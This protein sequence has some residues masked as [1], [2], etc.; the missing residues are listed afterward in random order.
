[1][2]VSRF[3]PLMAASPSRACKPGMGMP[4]RSIADLTRQAFSLVKCF[5]FSHQQQGDLRH[6]RQVTARAHRAFL[7]HHRGYTLVQH[8]HIGLGDL[9][10]AARV[11]MGMHIDP[12][13]H[14]CADIFDRHRLAN[15]SGMVVDQVALELLHLVIIEHP[16][17]EFANPGVHPVHDLMRLH[18]LLKHRP[19]RL[20][21]SKASGE[22][23]TSSPSRAM[24]TS[25]S[26]VNPRSHQA[27]WSLISP[28]V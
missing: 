14:G 25:F 26:S 13:S 18:L 11:A 17:G 9:R 22:R 8:V 19:A 1:M 10:T 21:T 16:L 6:R 28:Y 23:A 3:D 27:Q 5:A 7:A 20:D 4:A 24:R 2:A 15:P 12:P